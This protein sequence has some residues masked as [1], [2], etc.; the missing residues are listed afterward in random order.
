MIYP[1]VPTQLYSPEYSRNENLIVSLGRVV[2]EK[3]F[4][5]IGVV[6]PRVP[7][8]KF[9][10]IGGADDTG[11]KIVREIEEKFGKAGLIGNFTYLGRVSQLEKR[12][13]LQ[14]AKVLFHPAPYESFGIAIVEGMAAGAI[15]VA[16]NSGAAPEYV[17][18]DGLFVDVEE[19][20][21]KIRNALGEGASAR[22]EIREV[23]LKFS[24]ERFK[25]E[26]LTVVDW[27]IS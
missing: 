8:A 16:H 5:L 1:P 10:L 23:A 27:F 24:E 20:A 7:E 15:P 4:D 22:K 6:G 2:P 11:R 18:Y 14:K 19:A 3:R 17:S 21:E 13:I 25:N 9:I 26:L 12:S